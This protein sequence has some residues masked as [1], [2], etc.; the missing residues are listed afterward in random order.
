MTPA[1]SR[2]VGRAMGKARPAPTLAER[3]R[4]LRAMEGVD[5]FR[6]LPAEVRRLVVELERRAG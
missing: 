4:I 3:R 1:M 5:R 6:D 2:R